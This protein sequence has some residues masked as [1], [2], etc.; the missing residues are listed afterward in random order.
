MA[1]LRA[2]P[3]RRHRRW[4]GGSLRR[5][6][7][8]RHPWEPAPGAPSPGPP[9]RVPY[10]SLRTAPRPRAARQAAME[11]HV[12]KEHFAALIDAGFSGSELKE[13]I[14]NGILLNR[15]VDAIRRGAEVGQGVTCQGHTCTHTHTHTYTH[16]HTHTHTPPH[17][18][19]VTQGGGRHAQGRRGEGG[20]GAQPDPL[21]VPAQP[22]KRPCRVP[23]FPLPLL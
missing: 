3:L 23:F 19:H 16:T 20:T 2:A 22:A 1:A 4:L 15:V 10:T 11:H 5:P 13:L 7:A 9:P 8:P 6:L 21:A 18:T 14:S 12:S 17:T